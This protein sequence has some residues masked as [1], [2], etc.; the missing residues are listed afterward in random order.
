MDRTVFN[1][2]LLSING[3]GVALNAVTVIAILAV[4]KLRTTQNIFTLNIALSDMAAALMSLIITF[5]NMSF[6]AQPVVVSALLSVAYTTGILSTLAVAF[7]RFIVIKLDPFNNRRL[8]TRA[9]CIITSIVFWLM[10]SAIFVTIHYNVLENSL[11]GFITPIV[12][13]GS[14]IASAL[15][16]IIIYFA[17]AASARRAG[18]SAQRAKQNARILITFALVVGTN[19]LCWAPGCI[20]IIILYTQPR[21]S[22][23][24]LGAI[25][26]QV[27][28]WWLISANSVLN[29]II[30]WSR[31]SDFRKFLNKICCSKP[32]SGEGQNP[33]SNWEGNE[34][35]NTVA[36]VSNTKM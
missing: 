16:Y 34:T 25:L 22:W 24:K 27:L 8:V 4:K 2:V 30:Y 29:P 1:S 6:I 5:L 20:Y 15:C 14:H 12:I 10:N 33:S 13:L 11:L 32:L 3:L 23:G 36:S 19:I 17:V 35:K 9:R 26:I 7:H 21:S 18:I 28:R 31:L